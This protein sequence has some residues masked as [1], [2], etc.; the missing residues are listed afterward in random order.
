M[1]DAVQHVR[2]RT[3]RARAGAARLHGPR[4]AR[5]SRCISEIGIGMSTSAQDADEQLGALHRRARSSGVPLEALDAALDDAASVEDIRAAFVNLIL[6]A[7]TPGDAMD[8]DSAPLDES[9]EPVEMAAN[10]EGD[11]EFVACAEFA[12]LREGFVF[13]SGEAGV[14]Y[15]RDVRVSVGDGDNAQSPPA[16]VVGPAQVR[17]R[18]VL[19]ASLSSHALNSVCRSCCPTWACSRSSRSSPTRSPSRSR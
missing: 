16:A 17:H 15:Y 4:T 19:S 2:R 7:A 14:G 18:R 1:R 9:P 5:V 6:A 8:E 12:G 3:R 13:K 10:D 11:A